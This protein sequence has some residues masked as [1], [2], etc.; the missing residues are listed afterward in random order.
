MMPFLVQGSFLKVGDLRRA[1]LLSCS[2][3]QNRLLPRA[4]LHSRLDLRLD[5][6]EVETRSPLHGREFDGSLGELTHPLLHEHKTPKLEGEPV[7][8]R[9]RSPI[10]GGQVRSL[11]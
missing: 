2:P 6:F 10:A 3:L 4:A 5:R 8:E 7:V 1:R 11:E 9:P